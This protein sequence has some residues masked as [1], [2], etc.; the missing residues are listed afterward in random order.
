M[1]KKF[2]I[3]ALVAFL[4]VG[5]VSVAFSYRR[6]GGWGKPGM[7][8]GTGMAIRGKAELDLN[9]EQLEKLQ[10]LRADFDK[11]TLSLSN[12]LE[13]KALELRQLWTADELDEEAIIAKSKEVSD[14][15]SQLQEKTVR[16]R[17]DVAKVLTKEQRTQFLARGR[18]SHS[19]GPRGFGGGGRHGMGRGRGGRRGFGPARRG[20]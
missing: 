14:L 17:L 2:V 6:R 9:K 1:K 8:P 16:H 7:G 10:S 4:V 20:W 15:Q 18:R 12:E 11:D 5:T 19:F 3:I 13:L